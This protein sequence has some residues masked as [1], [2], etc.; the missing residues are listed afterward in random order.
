MVLSIR[1]YLSLYR[2]I[3]LQECQ[4]IIKSKE[5]AELKAGLS[6]E[7]RKLIKKNHKEVS[8]FAAKFLIDN[9]GTNLSTD[10]E[11]QHAINESLREALRN[12]Q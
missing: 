8:D 4:A 10:D 9:F 3:F 11:R 5:Y 7:Q 12:F 1:E 2:K 6:H